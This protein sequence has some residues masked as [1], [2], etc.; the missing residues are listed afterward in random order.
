MRQIKL[1]LIGYGR[2][3]KIHADNILQMHGV[4]LALVI[5]PLLDE[6]GQLFDSRTKT[7]KDIKVLTASREIDGVIICSPSIYHI[8]QI[9]TAATK[10]KN[11]FCEKPLALDPDEIASTQE[12]SIK[13]NLNLH[14]GFNRRFDPDFQKLKKDIYDGV[15]GDIYQITITSRDP[16]PPSIDYIKESGGLFLDMTIHDFDMIRYL[17]NAE[18][19]EIYVKGKCMVDPNIGKAGDIDTAIINMK[20]TN[21]VIASIINSRKAVYGYDQRIEILGSKGSLQVGNQ[22]LHGINKGTERGFSSGNPKNFFI[23][24]YADSY[25]L[26]MRNFI[27]SIKGK[28]VSYPSVRDALKTLEVGIAANKSLL[29]NKPIQ[30]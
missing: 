3:G 16:S 18:V 27:D 14:I 8:D 24:R 7:S 4:E 25:E 28:N 10:I 29:K 19:D 15:I 6:D 20:L 1:A 22:L 2:I 26:E 30:L 17:T 13:Q 23:D 11:L 9:K 12:L 5:D 21:S